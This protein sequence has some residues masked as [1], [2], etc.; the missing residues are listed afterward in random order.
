M[1][2]AIA[3]NGSATDSNFSSKSAAASGTG[4]TQGTSGGETSLKPDSSSPGG[5]APA[6][7]E[8]IKEMATS[9]TRAV[10][11]Q[12]IQFAGDMGEE[13]SK[14]A[15]SQKIRGAEAMRSF[16]RAINSAAGEL[17]GTSPQVARSVRDAAAKVE[18][19]STNLSS[20]SVD[21]L[22]K[23]ATDLARA[24]PL[25]FVGGAVA[26]GFALSRFLKTSASNPTSAAS[27]PAT[28]SQS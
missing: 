16:A 7:T 20:H 12:A 22:V 3:G 24:Q 17:E 13:L 2:T 14:T 10:K 27:T 9:A 21:D 8:G 1:D 18:D 26:A 4:Q 5:A 15:E 23:A 11:E 6:L 28:A 19:L 25:I